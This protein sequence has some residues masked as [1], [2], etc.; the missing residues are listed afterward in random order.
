VRRW[1][2]VLV[3][4]GVIV[5]IGF[6]AVG[7]GRRAI[8]GSDP[9]A[10]PELC[11]TLSTIDVG[12]ALGGDDPEARVAAVTAL[13]GIGDRAP[14][15]IRDQT[16]A[17]KRLAGEH[18][19]IADAAALGPDHPDAFGAAFQA[20][21]TLRFDPEFRAASALVER[22]AFERCGVELSGHFDVE[23]D[24]ALDPSLVPG[25]LGEIEDL[26]VD[27]DEATFE[28]YQLDPIEDPR[29]EIDRSSFDQ[30]RLELEPGQ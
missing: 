30:Y 23:V 2:T 11:E 1:L 7:P 20:V 5:A 21:Y 13:A 19:A 9:V 12:A 3:A 17:L 10:A 24:A 29:S 18:P 28:P 6:L 27:F 16:S 4:F 14:V 8:L 26:R 25:G 22:Y 15:E